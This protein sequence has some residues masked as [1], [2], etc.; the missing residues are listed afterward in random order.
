MKRLI[1][2]GVLGGRCLAFMN[3]DRFEIYTAK[4]SQKIL[5]TVSH[6]CNAD[7][8]KII[9]HG[10][11]KFRHNINKNDDCIRGKMMSVPIE[12]INKIPISAGKLASTMYTKM[13]M[14][15]I[16]QELGKLGKKTIPQWKNIVCTLVQKCHSNLNGV[17]V[18][19]NNN[20]NNRSGV[21]KEQ[22]K[23][24]QCLKQELDSI[25]TKSFYFSLLENKD[26]IF[27]VQSHPSNIV[28]FEW[29]VTGESKQESLY[30]VAVEYVSIITDCKLIDHTFFYE[31]H[32]L[33]L[34]ET[35]QRHCTDYANFHSKC[36]NVEFQHIV[37]EI[38]S[39]I[40]KFFG[41]GYKMQ[42]AVKQLQ[43]SLKKV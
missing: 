7:T 5:H 8:V 12:T 2:G 17:N 34:E 9:I 13:N 29:N 39:F 11:S 42:L 38:L 4:Y 10:M 19:N 33:I 36:I 31:K 40:F 1:W 35:I 21:G 22:M 20:N 16:E 32:S 14:Q 24:L 37:A 26:Y 41:N 18:N 27:M 30:P 6:E 28:S 3:K 15:L 23:S 25:D 43:E